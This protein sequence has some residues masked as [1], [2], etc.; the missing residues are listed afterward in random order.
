[1]ANPMGLSA[2][3]WI[4]YPCFCH[5]RC[6]KAHPAQVVSCYHWHWAYASLTLALLYLEAATQTSKWWV[7]RSVALWAIWVGHKGVPGWGAKWEWTGSDLHCC[8]L[9]SVPGLEAQHGDPRLR[10]EYTYRPTYAL[11]LM[12]RNEHP[13]LPWSPLWVPGTVAQAAQ[14]WAV[15][16][17]LLLTVS[18]WP[19]GLS[20]NTQWPHFYDTVI[21]P[22]DQ[23]TWSWENQARQ[24][25][26]PTTV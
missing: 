21:I 26:C 15:S 24:T 6:L 7:H 11:T 18:L 17:S 19:K 16:L 3:V 23:R 12:K 10:G 2:V 14:D 5:K 1:M 4:Y 13:L 22:N 20:Y 8:T 9:S 25:I